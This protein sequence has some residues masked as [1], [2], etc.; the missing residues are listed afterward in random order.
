M[1]SA[2]NNAPRILCCKR[3]LWQYWAETEMRFVTRK[4]HVQTASKPQL[5]H[6]P[7][8]CHLPDA[9]IVYN[10]S[11]DPKYRVQNNLEKAGLPRDVCSLGFPVPLVILWCL[12]KILRHL[13]RQ[14]WRVVPDPNFCCIYTVLQVR[15]WNIFEQNVTTVAKST[16]E[17]WTQG[18]RIRIPI[19]SGSRRAKMTQKS[20][21]RFYKIM[22]WSVVWPL[23]RVEGF[24][25][26]LDVLYGGLGIGT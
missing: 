19:G 3:N 4:R 10:L 9:L 6:V 23:L 8:I 20:R 15:F 14:R 12:C 18:L 16:F 2:P 7:N 25:C 1:G 24:F 26:N 13:L 21:K 11:R 17:Q 5:G 22:F